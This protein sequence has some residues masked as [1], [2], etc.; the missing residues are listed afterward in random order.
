MKKYIYLVN[1]DAQ[2]YGEKESWTIPCAN[3]KVARREFFRTLQE[4]D[5]YMI[6]EGWMINDDGIAKMRNVKNGWEELTNETSES[7]KTEDLAVTRSEPGWGN[8]LY[9]WVVKA[10]IRQ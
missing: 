7:T 4:E 5:G 6:N 10:E 2:Y 1:Y 8:H 9:L 3:D